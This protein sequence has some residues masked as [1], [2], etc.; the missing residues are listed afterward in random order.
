MLPQLRYRKDKTQSR[1]KPIFPIVNEV[2][3]LSTGCAVVAV[4]HYYCPDLLRLEGM[5]RRCFWTS[6]CSRIEYKLQFFLLLVPNGPFV[7]SLLDRCLYE[8][9]HVCSGQPVQPAFHPWVLR[10]LFKKLLFLGTGRYA[11]RT[12]RASGT[13]AWLPTLPHSLPHSLTNSL[14][15]MYLL[16]NA[17]PLGHTTFCTCTLLIPSECLLSVII[18]ILVETETFWLSCV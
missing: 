2:K 1:Q 14:T 11:L 6:K 17:N 10:K 12:T 15:H 13:H 4:M 7:R 5:A 3:D 18:P 16:S 8:G 9:C